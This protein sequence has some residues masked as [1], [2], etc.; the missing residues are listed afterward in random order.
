MCMSMRGI[1][2]AGSRTVTSAVRG[3]FQRDGKVR[4]EAMSLIMHA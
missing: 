3:V 4:A 1:Q 2:K